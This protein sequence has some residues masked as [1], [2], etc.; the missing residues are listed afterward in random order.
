MKKRNSVLKMV[1][2]SVC[3]VIMLCFTSCAAKT[4]DF[5]D[6]NPQICL[7]P[8]MDYEASWSYCNNDIQDATEPTELQ[9]SICNKVMD[10]VYQIYTINK[11]RPKIVCKPDSYFKGE[12][13]GS[14][15]AMARYLAPVD[16]IVISQSFDDTQ[17]SFFCHELMHYFSD[18]DKDSDF[19]GL[20]Y[21]MSNGQEECMLGLGLN[22]G[23][24]NYFSTKIYQHPKEFCIYEFETHV[25]AEIAAVYGDSEL[26]RGFTSG[27]YESL[28]N[29]FN[30]CVGTIYPSKTCE[31]YNLTPFDLF[32]STMDDYYYFMVSFDGYAYEYGYE[33]ATKHFASNVNTIES[34]MLNYGTTIGKRSD[35]QAQMT[36]LLSTCSANIDFKNL[37]KIEQYSIEV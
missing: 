23:I 5:E 4:N 2:L 16:T 27:D 6:Y 31:N 9:M 22:E 1:T 30:Q 34:M 36:K 15:N 26:W 18:T 19:V 3:M 11:E 17:K 21:S 37:S 10:M 24:A 14:M 7:S 33:A 35:V 29:H 20:E 13:S 8:V 12:S 32:Q 28:R 25:A